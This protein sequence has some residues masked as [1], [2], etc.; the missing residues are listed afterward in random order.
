MSIRRRARSAGAQIT[1]RQ[2]H[3]GA[4]G[5]PERELLPLDKKARSANGV[6]P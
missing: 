3:A 4:P 6:H 1:Q 2:N 5:R